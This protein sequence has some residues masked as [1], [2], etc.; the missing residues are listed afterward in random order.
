MGYDTVSVLRALG[1]SQQWKLSGFPTTIAEKEM[2][3]LCIEFPDGSLSSLIVPEKQ[4]D[5]PRFE[6]DW[7][8][9]S[10]L[11][12]I[13]TA[14]SKESTDGGDQAP[15]ATKKETDQSGPVQNVETKETNEL[16]ESLELLEKAYVTRSFSAIVTDYYDLVD[17]GLLQL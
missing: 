10:L 7:S 15:S 5:L 14:I 2:S 6:G 4:L 1:A 3:V 12:S 13:H 11:Q 17:K 16:S 9:E 8:V